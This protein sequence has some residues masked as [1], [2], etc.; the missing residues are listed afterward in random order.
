MNPE[1]IVRR[2][3]SLIA[4]PPTPIEEHNVAQAYRDWLVAVNPEMYHHIDHYHSCALAILPDG[5]SR[6]LKYGHTIKSLAWI[7][8]GES[9]R[10]FSL[11]NMCNIKYIEC[12]HV[13]A[14]YAGIELAVEIARRNEHLRCL[15]LDFCQKVPCPPVRLD[16]LQ[17]HFA[18]STLRLNFMNL[19]P[20]ELM[21]LQVFCPGLRILHLSGIDIARPT[22]NQWVLAHFRNLTELT[23]ERM[24]FIPGLIASCPRL[25]IL[26]VDA[27]EPLNS[28]LDSDVDAFLREVKLIPIRG[29]GL[30]FHR[31]NPHRATDAH[32]IAGALIGTY[33]SR[34]REL[35]FHDTPLH[36]K[37]A[38]DLRKEYPSDKYPQVKIAHFRIDAPFVF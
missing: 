18:L 38:L 35:R 12:L 23:L 28:A 29:L 19:T 30:C 6:V 15:Y 13:Q 1:D 17:N 21:T 16:F 5:F 36:A 34:L 7:S 32:A 25:D 33:G 4:N 31:H 11:F 22:I 24:A 14:P 37:L 2:L 26:R 10:E 3:Y 9:A 27:M 8:R 20:W